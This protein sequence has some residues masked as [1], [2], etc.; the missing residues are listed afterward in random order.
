MFVVTSVLTVLLIQPPQLDLVGFVLGLLLQPAGPENR[1]EERALSVSRTRNTV[2][3]STRPPVSGFHAESSWRAM[4]GRFTSPHPSTPPATIWHRG[5]EV[6]RT[7]LV[8]DYLGGLKN[9]SEEW[10]DQCT[11]NINASQGDYS[12]ASLH[13]ISYFSCSCESAEWNF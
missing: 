3:F 4:R 9:G 2:V 6:K 12:L 13:W 7:L 1:R 11:L 5:S 10:I 8:S